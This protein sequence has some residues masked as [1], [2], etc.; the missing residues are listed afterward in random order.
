MEW[1][2]TFQDEP[3]AVHPSWVFSEG[4]LLRMVSIEKC[5]CNSN[6]NC[7]RI[8]SCPDL[9]SK[10][11]LLCISLDLVM[12]FPT[13]GDCSS[14][15]PPPWQRFLSSSLY[16][17]KM[18]CLVLFFLLNS[19]Y[20][21]SRWGLIFGFVCLSGHLQWNYFGFAFAVVGLAKWDRW[22]WLAHMT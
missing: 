4:E 14:K 9:H 17:L 10:S 12:I 11:H 22:S 6:R 1:F 5:Q 2:C 21:S 19:F 20:K 13:W 3:K 8:L 16:S 18:S 15:A 7:L